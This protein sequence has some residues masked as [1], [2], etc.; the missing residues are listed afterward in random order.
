MPGLRSKS[1]KALLAIS[2]RMRSPA[3]KRQEVGFEIEFP[4]MNFVRGVAFFA[5]KVN[6][7]GRC[8]CR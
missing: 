6:W 3:A 4:V 2:R 5:E 8:R 1:G 7:S